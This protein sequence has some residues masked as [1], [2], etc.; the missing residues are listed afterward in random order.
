MAAKSG[1]PSAQSLHRHGPG[2]QR[3][4]EEQAGGLVVGA[5]ALEHGLGVIYRLRIRCTA[6]RYPGLPDLDEQIRDGP[7]VHVPH[8][9]LD[10]RAQDIALHPPRP[11]LDEIGGQDLCQLQCSD[12]HWIGHSRWPPAPVSVRCI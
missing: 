2:P 11:R 12:C 4:V 8:A 9:A 3:D 7:L 1:G 10:G 6:R 5:H